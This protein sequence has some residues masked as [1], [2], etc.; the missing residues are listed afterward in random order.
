MICYDV[1]KE[2]GVKCMTR[3]SRVRFTFRIPAD[4]LVRIRVVAKRKGCSVNA[5]VLQ[6]LWDWLEQKEKPPV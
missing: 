5:L 2:R 3:D 4:M 6:I 1:A